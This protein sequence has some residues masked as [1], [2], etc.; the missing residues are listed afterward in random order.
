MDYWTRI[1]IAAM[2]GAGV[3]WGVGYLFGD[4][5]VWIFVCLAFA[6]ASE[7]SLRTIKNVGPPNNPVLDRMPKSRNSNESILRQKP[8]KPKF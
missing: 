8:P 5:L 6:L 2:L 4:Y 1:I 3:G 7:T